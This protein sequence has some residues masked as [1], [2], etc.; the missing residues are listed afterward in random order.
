MSKFF[1]YISQ[2]TDG[3]IAAA[4]ARAEYSEGW[5]GNEIEE[6]ERLRDVIGKAKQMLN[7]RYPSE[8]VA[9]FLHNAL[10]NRE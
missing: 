7:L 3:P 5:L 8:D 10:I 6:N 1:D 2:K 9:R 4:E